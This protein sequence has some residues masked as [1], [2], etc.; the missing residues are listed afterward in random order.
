MHNY[1]R[2]V[3][4]LK[5]TFGRNKKFGREIFFVNVVVFMGP[6]EESIKKI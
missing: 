1:K 2:N 6:K 4:K 5:S 3:K